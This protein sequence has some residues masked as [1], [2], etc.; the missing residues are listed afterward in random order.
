MYI[1]FKFESLL[2]R[3]AFRPSQC[4]E[5]NVFHSADVPFSGSQVKFDRCNSIKV[6]CIMQEVIDNRHK[7]VAHS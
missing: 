4:I 6:E 3:R 5:M 2:K 1:R 7:F